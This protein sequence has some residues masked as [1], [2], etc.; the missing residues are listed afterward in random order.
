MTTS[1][2]TASDAPTKMFSYSTTQRRN[3][4]IG[5]Q[6]PCP[7]PPNQSHAASPNLDLQ[8]SEAGYAHVRRVLFGSL[9]LDRNAES[10][11]LPFVLES[12]AAWIHRGVFDPVK[13]ARRMK[14]SIVERYTYSVETRWITILLANIIGR[15]AKSRL[16]S[17]A[18]SPKD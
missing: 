5:P 8:G 7:L 15:S 10:N 9:A 17:Q 14:C 1:R 6:L 13:V 18:C 11:S 2:S 16:M 4:T 3:M 12:Y